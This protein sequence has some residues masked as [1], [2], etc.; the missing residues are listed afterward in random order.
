MGSSATSWAEQQL[1]WFFS[2]FFLLKDVGAQ[3]SAHAKCRR[4]VKENLFF[5]RQTQKDVLCLFDLLDRSFDIDR[6]FRDFGAVWVRFVFVCA[7]VYWVSSILDGPFSLVE[8]DAFFVVSTVDRG[9]M[10]ECVYCSEW[11]TGIEW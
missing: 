8:V 5:K 1:L 7:S 4:D 10:S 6:R 2:P 11:I 9:F 3:Q